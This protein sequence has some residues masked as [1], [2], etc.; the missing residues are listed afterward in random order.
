M[1]GASSANEVKLTRYTDADYAADKA[2]RKSIS[3]SVLLV[4][5]MP[6]GWQVKQ[7]SSVALSNAEAEF[8]VA[9]V[10][11]KELL[12]VKNLLRKMNVS[13]KLPKQ[14]IMDN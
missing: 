3:G 6:V 13:V 5:G 8:V 14:M 2:T 7:P 9:A 4:D 11:A 12:C 1:G 10:V